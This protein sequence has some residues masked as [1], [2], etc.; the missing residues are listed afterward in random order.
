MR[1]FLPALALAA[2]LPLAV[3]ATTPVVSDAPATA[4]NT[5]AVEIV[6]LKPV[7]IESKN[8][9]RRPG[10]RIVV[11]DL[12][13][14]GNRVDGPFTTVVQDADAELWVHEIVLL[15]RDANGRVRVSA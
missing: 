4:L 11:Q 10:V 6:Q 5:T 9:A 7:V 15:I 14:H 13:G 12:D 3:Q 8:G 2:F 1:S